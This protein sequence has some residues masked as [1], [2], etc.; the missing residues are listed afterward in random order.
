MMHRTIALV[1]LLVLGSAHDLTGTL[2]PPQEAFDLDSVSDTLFSHCFIYLLGNSC[3]L[4]L[5]FL[6]ILYKSMFN[7]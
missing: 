2:P 7:V 6:T 1:L 4:C 3:V 5:V